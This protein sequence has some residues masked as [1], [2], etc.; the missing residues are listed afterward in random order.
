MSLT[1]TSVSHPRVSIVNS[2]NQPPAD[3]LDV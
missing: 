3:V 2:I 1:S